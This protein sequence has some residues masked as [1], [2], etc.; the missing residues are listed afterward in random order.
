LLGTEKRID[1][2]NADVNM[3]MRF[4]I[5]TLVHAMLQTDF[6]SMCGLTD[7]HLLFEDEVKI[8][9]RTNALAAQ[10][11]YASHCDGIFTFFDQGFNPY[12]RIGLEIK[13]MSGPEYETAKKP[14]EEHIAQAMLYQKVLD[15]PLIWYLY[16]NKSNSNFVSP[17]T[18]WL[19]PYDKNTWNRIE[20]RSQQV[21]LAIA[22]GV[23]PERE[24]GRHCTWC[25]YPW[26]CEPACIR[27]TGG[28][29]TS[30]VPRRLT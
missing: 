17:R 11:Q 13:T 24:E 1:A 28:R 5:G 14:K 19:V 4:D 8:S 27:R 10:Y 15:L 29:P 18:P 9:A 23:L 20:S 6:H 3:L 16:Y 22:Q 2:E 7:G 12:I 21:H 26:T 25:P 30:M